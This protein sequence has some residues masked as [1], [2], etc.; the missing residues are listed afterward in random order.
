MSKGLICVD[1]A[2]LLPVQSLLWEQPLVCADSQTVLGKCQ[3]P[4]LQPEGQTLGDVLMLV[5]LLV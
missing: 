1:M 4:C 3:G 2:W 5:N